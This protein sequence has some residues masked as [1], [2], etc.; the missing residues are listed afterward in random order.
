MKNTRR[1][2][3]V[4][5]KRGVFFF[6]RR[7]LRFSWLL[8]LQAVQVVRT[9][10]RGHFDLC[11]HHTAV[12]HWT[13][14]P[15]CYTEPFIRHVTLNRLSAML[16]W[17]VCTSVVPRNLTVFPPHIGINRRRLHAGGVH[18]LYHLSI[19]YIITARKQSLGQGN[20]FTP[21]CHSVHSGH[22]SGRYT[23]FLNAYLFIGVFAQSRQRSIAELFFFLFSV[24]SIGARNQIIMIKI[25]SFCGGWF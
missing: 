24:G 8:V 22:R 19:Y 9:V 4:D 10:R 13:V 15:P 23:S 5:E 7:Q 11:R 25:W 3:F 1:K 16:H 6:G 14:Y 17:T 18:F 21:V 2:M 12:L 20:V